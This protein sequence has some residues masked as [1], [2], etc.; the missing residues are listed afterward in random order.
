[1]YLIDSS[2]TNLENAIGKKISSQQ[3]SSVIWL[4]I[5]HLGAYT[6]TE[7]QVTKH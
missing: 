1:M 3:W 7:R 6:L 4:Y 5:Y 2:L